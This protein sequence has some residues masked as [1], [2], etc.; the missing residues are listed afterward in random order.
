MGCVL[1]YLLLSL[2]KFVLFVGYLHTKC[3][4]NQ[5]TK[6]IQTDERTDIMKLQGLLAVDNGTLTIWR[7]RRTHDGP[8]Y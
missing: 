6:Y 5:C 4:L 1:I 7:K 2:Y 3:H 8:Q